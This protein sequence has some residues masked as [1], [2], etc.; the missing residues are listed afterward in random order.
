VNR[1]VLLVDDSEELLAV[2]R[3]LLDGRFAVHVATSADEAL[4]LL[5]RQGPFAVVVSDQDMPGKTGL[6]FFAALRSSAPETLRILCSGSCAGQL[7]LRGLDEVG[8]FRFL[9][10]PLTAER[11]RAAVE[12][13]VERYHRVVEERLLTEQL[14]FARESLLEITHALEH[15]LAQQALQLN[16]LE[17]LNAALGH[18]RSV[19]EIARESCAAIVRLLDGRGSRCLL[20]DPLTG[21]G[22]VESSVRALAAPIVSVPLV[23]GERLY[24]YLE[25]EELCAGATLTPSARR[26]LGA[27]AAATAVAARTQAHRRERD[28]A[29]HAAIFA[30]A[31]LAEYR[32]DETGRHLERVSG[33]A[34]LVAE[35]LR[36]A[37]R[38]P[39][40]LSDGFVRDLVLAAPLHDIGKVGIPDAVLLKPGKLTPEEWVVMRRHTTIGAETLRAVLE[41]AGEQSFLRLAH[42]IAWC[43]HE[44]WDGN[45]Y[46][47][48]LVGQ[49]I[50]LAARIVSIADCYD[51]L[52]TRRP[53][54][55]PWTHAD[56]LA[57]IGEQA[58]AQFDPDVVAAFQ[59]RAGE[60]DA[61][62]GQ[63]ADGPDDVSR[64]ERSVRESKSA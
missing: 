26:V 4:A 14:A 43:H 5:A 3:E 58:G 22:A 49:E 46:P 28:C 20:E 1:S 33:Y 29:Q 56:A 32:D 57:W 36:E 60:A 10:K 51:A 35:A 50:P 54:K 18:A 7:A 61:I 6:E 44:R 45:G 37:G 24:G 30:L 8:I 27:V 17:A 53:Y 63:L 38:Y 47:R 13:A 25:V 9:E 12:E 62:R 52:T 16:E 15:R 31:R 39:G 34:R 55:G 59:A 41:S 23:A 64:L 19:E 40:V 21:A 48:G 2:A 42:E 11:L